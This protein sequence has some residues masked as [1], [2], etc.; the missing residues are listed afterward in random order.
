MVIAYRPSVVPR[1]A[2]EAM[3]S[4]N[5]TIVLD[6]TASRIRLASLGP[7]LLQHAAFMVTLA[8][9]KPLMVNS[10]FWKENSR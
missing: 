7:R 1:K 5:I 9:H 4:Q 10:R 6:Y 8:E 3:S 2:H